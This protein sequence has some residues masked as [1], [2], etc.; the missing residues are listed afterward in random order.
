VKYILSLGALSLIFSSVAFTHNHHDHSWLGDKSGYLYNQ[1][2]KSNLKNNLIKMSKSGVTADEYISEIDETYLKSK[3]ELLSGAKDVNLGGTLGT[4]RIT[5]RKSKNGRTLAREFLANEYRELGYD[6]SMDNFGGTFS[7][8]ANFVAKKV[9][10]HPAAKVLVLTSHIDSVGNAGAN[11]NGSGTISA[12]AVARALSSQTFKHT[13][14]IVGFDKEESGLV[15]SK[16]YVK[17]ITNKEE[18]IGNINFEM[19]GTNSRNDGVFHI[20]DCDRADSKYLSS[21]ITSTIDNYNLPLAINPGCTTRSDHASF[22]KADLPAI[23]ISE[24]FFGGDSDRCYH[25]SCDIVD[26]RINFTYMRHI[27]YAI[28][29]AIVQLLQ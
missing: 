21:A 26:E 7:K 1:T 14:I 18:I 19:M 28:Y 23:V 3:L 25:K 24:N 29:G 17:K 4:V 16:A 20:I 11:D 22:W 6:V 2:Q 13:I 8:G 5:E 10:N 12:L 15:G 27:T 9:S